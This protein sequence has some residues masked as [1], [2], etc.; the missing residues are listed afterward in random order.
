VEDDAAHKLDIEVAFAYG[1]P[2]GFSDGSEGF[3]QDVIQRLAILKPG[4]EF[5]GPGTKLS[6]VEL[7]K[8]WLERIYLVYN[9]LKTL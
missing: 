6:V 9:R 8:I 3:R 5:I 4:F 2:G 1:A 7:L